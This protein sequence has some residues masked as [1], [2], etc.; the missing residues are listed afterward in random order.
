[1]KREEFVFTIGYQGGVAIVDSHAFKRYKKYSTLRLLE[2]GLFKAAFCSA[3][4]DDNKEE[5]QLIL[6][7]YNEKSEHRYTS[8]EDL[9]RVFGVF[10][11]TASDVS[12][13]IL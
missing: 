3:L 13:N 12:V 4:W 1:M 6:D 5:Q 7:R 2:E 9:K 8:V 11:V 10:E